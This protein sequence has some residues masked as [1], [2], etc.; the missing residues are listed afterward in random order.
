MKVESS[1]YRTQVFLRMFSF[2][3]DMLHFSKLKQ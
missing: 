1:Y 2:P 3:Q